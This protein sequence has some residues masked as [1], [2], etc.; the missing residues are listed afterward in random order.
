MSHAHSHSF[1]GD[2]SAGNL[3]KTFIRFLVSIF[4]VLTV[5]FILNYFSSDKVETLRQNNPQVEYNNN[6]SYYRGKV[7]SVFEEKPADGNVSNADG[8]INQEMEIKP[9]EGPEKDSKLSIVKQVNGNDDRQKFR[10]GDEVVLIRDSNSSQIEYSVLEKYR[11]N[12]LFLVFLVFLVG[13]LILVGLKGINSFLGLIFSITVLITFLIPQLLSGGNLILT[14]FV[15]GLLI[16]AV[17]LYLSHGFTKRTTLTLIASTITITIATLISIVAVNFVGLSGTASDDAFQLQFA[18]IGAISFRGLLL[19]G[20][21]IGCM[22]VLD[23]VTTAQAS[24]IEQ[25]LTENPKITPKK[26]YARGLTIGKDHLVSMVNTLGLAYVGASLPLLIFFNIYNT[27][28][29]WV[30]LNSEVIA[31]EIVRTLMGSLSLLLA[32]PVI[33][34][35]SAYFLKPKVELKSKDLKVQ[36]V[37]SEDLNL[38]KNNTKSSKKKFN[39]KTLFS[40]FKKTDKKP[41]KEKPQKSNENKKEDVGGIES[42]RSSK[43]EQESDSKNEQEIEKEVEKEEPPKP[44]KK[45]VQL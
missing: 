39:L 13:I 18:G 37:D 38:S 42:E 6:L 1:D 41:K 8:F 29:I 15:T 22:G 34:V 12:S 5:P 14:T 17:S 31:E 32:V 21:I 24:A 19:A 27:S 30:T 43:I 44:K 20:I 7:E 3:K 36:M 35:L 45:T 23:D 33:T 9:L 25:I 10:E 11:L 2:N 16:M 28:P 40:S 26:L 4:I